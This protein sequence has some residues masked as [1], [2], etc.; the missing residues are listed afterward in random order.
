MPPIKMTKAQSD[1]VYSIVKTFYEKAKNI[2]DVPGDFCLML[3]AI[4]KMIEDNTEFQQAELD[5]IV[6][7]LE[8]Y[9]EAFDEYDV[10][11]L[12]EQAYAKI[13]GHWPEQFSEPWYDRCVEHGHLLGYED[14]AS[15]R[16][17]LGY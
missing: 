11:P 16:D 12:A 15:S 4:Q 9:F 8:C 6:F 17:K 14:K 7:V 10:D 2:K 5:I 13:M 1:R 3:L